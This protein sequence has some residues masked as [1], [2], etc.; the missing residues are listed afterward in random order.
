MASPTVTFTRSRLAV[1]CLACNAS[2][3]FSQS[4][5]NDR[6]TQTP[7]KHVIVVVGEN[8]TFDS[9]FATYQPAAGRTVDNLLSKQIINADGTPGVNYALAR[10]NIARNTGT[11][12]TLDP[13]RVDPYAVLPRPILELGLIDKRFPRNLANGPFQISDYVPYSGPHSQT[14]DPVHRFFQMWQ[15]TGGDNAN[16]DLFVWVAAT[17]GQGGNTP[18][19]FPWRPAQGGELMGFSN[20]ATGDAPYFKALADSYAM[21]DN[22]H[23]AIMGGTGMNFFSIATGDLPVYNRDGELMPPPANQIE[24]PDPLAGTANFYSRDGYYGGSYVNCADNTQPGVAAIEAKL[25]A[26]GIDKNCDPNAYYLVNNYNPAYDLFGHP[27][28]LGAKDYNFP[29]QQV[30]TIAEALSANQVSWKWYTGGRETAMLLQKLL[31]VK[32][33][34]T[35]ASLFFYN[36]IGD[37]LQGSTAV[38]NSPLFKNLQGLGGF[39]T[40]LAN[41]TLPAV[42]YVVP[43]YGESG[44]PG[45]SAPALYENFV[46]KLVAKVQANPQL[47]AETAIIVTTDEGGGYFDSGRIQ[48]LDFFG[49]GPRIPFF[50]ISP[51]AKRGH[52]DHVYH[53][54]ASVLKF[55]EYN[56]QLPALSARSR[57]RLPNPSDDS[58]LPANSPAIGDLMTMFDW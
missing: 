1:A 55:I 13:E 23:Q 44:H 52:V 17:T 18:G 21:S 32:L 29:P 50:V 48:M 43:F 8:H 14:G 10:Q 56:W 39:D 38:V 24:N 2:L 54:H 16:L 57:D 11:T 22:F 45:N 37:P 27:Q 41:G 58:Y 7:I 36:N 5:I 31:G 15:Q 26:M 51:Y 47:W 42:S 4:D 6:Y 25:S 53:D 12:Y 19:V 20:M 3:A 30:P 49:D 33:G 9:L 34:G 46:E 40:D 28:A 35:L